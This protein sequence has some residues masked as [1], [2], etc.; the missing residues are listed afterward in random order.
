M[1]CQSEKD[2]KYMKE[3]SE[4]QSK[5][6]TKYSVLRLYETVFCSMSDFQLQLNLYYV[7]YEKLSLSSQG[8]AVHTKSEVNLQR[9]HSH[10][11]KLKTAVLS[12]QSKKAN[13]TQDNSSIKG[14]L[15]LHMQ[16]YTNVISDKISKVQGGVRVMVLTQI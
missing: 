3:Q 14:L 13:N 2:I 6:L 11:I 7:Y 1:K 8:Q 12:T 10:F 16:S 15:P 5:I 9:L 4:K